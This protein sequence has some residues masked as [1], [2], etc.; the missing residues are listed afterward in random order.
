MGCPNWQDEHLDEFN[1]VQGD[2]G[3]VSRSGIIM[4]SHVGCGTWR[5]K[6]W[7]LQIGNNKMDHNWTR[8]LVDGF[9][10][11]D[12]ARYCIPESQTWESLPLS[13]QFD[14]VTNA[15]SV[16]EKQILL[17]P[18]CCGRFTSIKILVHSLTVC[19]CLEL[20]HYL[21]HLFII[22]IVVSLYA[23]QIFF[24]VLWKVP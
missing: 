5:T 6:L 9:H 7:D 22:I 1:K 15:N 11:V 10:L 23:E 20:L 3:T 12:Q 13:T 17:L 19:I 16:G 24:R 8:C 14:A 4:I 18:A 2:A 21:F